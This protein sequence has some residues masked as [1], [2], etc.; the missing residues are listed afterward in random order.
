MNEQ[1]AA[2][3]ITAPLH[4]VRRV[5]LQ[6]LALPDWNPAI[7]SLTGPAQAQIGTRYPIVAKG[8]LRGFWTYVAIDEHRIRTQFK[9]NGL[10]EQGWWTLE[11]R[12]ENTMVEHGFSHRGALALLLSVGFRGVADLRLNRLAERS[13]ASAA[14]GDPTGPEGAPQ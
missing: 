1:T 8:G 2:R 11:P 13:A 3:L 10:E 9:V 7:L 4:Q 5:L 6:P 14:S 12:G